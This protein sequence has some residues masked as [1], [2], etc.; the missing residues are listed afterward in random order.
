MLLT[1]ENNDAI[2]LL[3]TYW[4]WTFG[5]SLLYAL[6]SCFYTPRQYNHGFSVSECCTWV[7]NVIMCGICGI[8]GICDIRVMSVIR[9]GVCVLR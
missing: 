8:C 1:K 5:V 7:Q 2:R 6:Y 4:H 9:V 3:H